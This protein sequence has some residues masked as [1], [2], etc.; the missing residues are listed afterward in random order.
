MVRGRQTPG[1]DHQSPVAV[2]PND[3]MLSFPLVARTSAVPSVR[4]TEE[5]SR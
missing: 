1:T 2:V 4:S 3:V 5:R